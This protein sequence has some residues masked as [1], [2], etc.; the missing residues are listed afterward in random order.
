M[1]KKNL[2]AQRYGWTMGT[3]SSSSQNNFQ[4]WIKD[5]PKGDYCVHPSG[6][7]ASHEFMRVTRPF[8]EGRFGLRYRY[9]A[10]TLFIDGV[11][12]FQQRNIV[13]RLLTDFGFSGAEIHLTGIDFTKPFS[14]RCIPAYGGNVIS[15]INLGVQKQLQFGNRPW[16]KLLR[17]RPKTYVAEFHH[18]PKGVPHFMWDQNMKPFKFTPSQTRTYH[19]VRS[20]FELGGAYPVIVGHGFNNV[21]HAIEH[22][23][24]L[25]HYGYPKLQRPGLHQSK[26]FQL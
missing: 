2:L 14:L 9:D 15:G 3:I 12:P 11:S 10:Q 7:C 18:L 21:R 1:T 5:I 16:V 26:S 13:K 6:K 20:R 8:I 25:N 4:L 22:F 23:A 19:L 17:P 24:S